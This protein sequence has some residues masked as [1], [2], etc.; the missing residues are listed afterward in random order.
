MPYFLTDRDFTTRKKIWKDYNNKKECYLMHMKSVKIEG[1]PEKS[2]P[3][4]GNFIIRAGY[5]CPYNDG[6]EE[7]KCKF[8]FVTCFDMKLTFPLALIKNESIKEQRIW[9]EDLIKNINKHEE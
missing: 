9:A 5:I 1:Y 2:K 6:E 4:R 7:E 8:S 3:I